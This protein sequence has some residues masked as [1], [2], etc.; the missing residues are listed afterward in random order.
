MGSFCQFLHFTGKN[1]GMEWTRCW[2]LFPQFCSFEASK[3]LYNF[4]VKHLVEVHLN[5]HTCTEWNFRVMTKTTIWKSHFCLVWNGICEIFEYSQS[6]LLDK[7]ISVLILV[8][9]IGLGFLI[10]FFL[11]SWHCFLLVWALIQL[12]SLFIVASSYGS[13]RTILTSLHQNCIE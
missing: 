13:Y 11:K 6:G 4:A 2:E 1:N 8:C 3:N 7:H 9:K 5:L 12:F 10:F